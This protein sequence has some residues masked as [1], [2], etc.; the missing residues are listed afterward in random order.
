MIIATSD[1]LAGPGAL[2]KLVLLTWAP[3]QTCFSPWAFPRNPK[4]VH[5]ASTTHYCCQ[6]CHPLKILRPKIRIPENTWEKKTVPLS[7]HP[8]VTKGPQLTHYLHSTSYRSIYRLNTIGTR[9]YWVS[10]VIEWSVLNTWRKFAANKQILALKPDK[11]LLKTICS[12]MFFGPG[13]RIFFF[14]FSTGIFWPSL[15]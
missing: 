7:V 2:I 12:K 9:V 3:F 14:L 1:F 13:T 10:W 8:S 5:A 6:N 11:T 4:L 15:W